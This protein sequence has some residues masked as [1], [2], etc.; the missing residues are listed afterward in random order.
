MFG[1]PGVPF[2]LNNSMKSILFCRVSSKEQADEGYSL[3]A[4]EK[5]LRGYAEQNGFK[6][7]KV[8]KIAETASKDHV[9]KLFKEIFQFANKYNVNFIL[10]EKIDRLTRNLKDAAIVDDWVKEDTKRAVHFVKEHFILNENTKA[11]DNF[12]W[13]MKVAVARF[14]A[15]NLSEEVHKGQNEKLA[16]GWMPA[17]PTLGYKTIGEKGH[18]THVFDEQKAPLVKRMFEYYST[19]RY[20]LKTLVEMMYEAGL[21]SY[22][23][24]KLG[25]SRMAGIFGDPFYY[26]KIRWMGTLYPGNQAPLITKELFD[27][28]QEVLR[29]KTNPR[30]T[31]HHHLF[32]GLIGCADCGYLITWEKQKG[33]VYGHCNKYHNC[34]KRKWYIENEIEKQILPA[35]EQLQIK[36]PRLMDW[37]KKALREG[38]KDEVE[39]NQTALSELQKQYTAI[40]SRLD[41]LYDDKLDEKITQDMYDRKFQQYSEDR[42]RILQS[43]QKH[44]QSSDR[45]VELG[46]ALY[47]LSQK[48]KDIY[49]KAEPEQKRKLNNLVLTG[50]KIDNGLLSYEYTKPFKL[51]L[52]AIKATNSS[53][54]SDFGKMEVK[55]SNSEIMAKVNEKAPV[56][57]DAVSYGS[58]GRIRTCDLG[59]T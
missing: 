36:N 44:S 39:Y 42:D 35:Y 28:V 1:S 9:R 57:P 40:Q 15:N 31:S 54:R 27:K 5:L 50:L 7:A 46:V 55:L 43:I 11:H 4:Q 41:R 26:G 53:D 16:Q 34:K 18:K 38:H 49:L 22:S 30:H 24:N 13:D 25:K 59:I 21:R 48:A 29:G 56:L 3:E 32:K 37:I 6:I 8:Y 45:Y 51:L 12:V 52:E 47:E 19:G 17:K 10:C 33:S 2:G 23:G 20:S 14:Y 58:G